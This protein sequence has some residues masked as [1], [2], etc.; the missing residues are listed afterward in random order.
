MSNTVIATYDNA[1]E[2]NNA[3]MGLFQQ[4]F[5]REQISMLTSDAT[6]R[7]HLAIEA[8]TKA[9]EGAAA[10]AAIGGTLG[11]IVAGL[12]AVGTVVVPGVGLVVA[13]PL[14]AALA[15]LGAGGAAGGL[16]GGLIGAGMT[17][18]EAKMVEDAVKNGN[19]V[20][21]VTHEDKERINNAR[22]VFKATAALDIAAA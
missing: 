16:V 11:A 3:I 19:I 12:T 10:G 9:P 15:G 4:G 21:A 7:E 14:L 20:I 1:R 17:E 18:A 2:A 13:G 5:S 8:N 6:H 22:T